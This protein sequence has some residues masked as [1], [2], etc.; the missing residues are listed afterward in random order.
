MSRVKK[1][2]SESEFLKPEG[3][4]KNEKHVLMADSSIIDKLECL[5]P[6]YE[7][8]VEIATYLTIYRYLG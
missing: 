5:W 3:L 6:I 2:Q 4:L 8:E 1:I 7:I